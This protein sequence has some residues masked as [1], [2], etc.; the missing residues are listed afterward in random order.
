MG[1]YLNY[2]RNVLNTPHP[3][4]GGGLEG[5]TIAD[6]PSS[7]QT[8]LSIFAAVTGNQ[9]S[10]AVPIEANA[11]EITTA[12]SD[13]HTS[14]DLQVYQSDGVTLLWTFKNVNSLTGDLYLGFA[15]QRIIIGGGALI[16]KTANFS[17]TGTVTCTVRRTG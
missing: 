3:M 15:Q 6:L 5:F 16:F 11:I 4:Y 13:N 17:G 9:T 1:D 2:K 14:F 7:G 12:V 8:G 10:A